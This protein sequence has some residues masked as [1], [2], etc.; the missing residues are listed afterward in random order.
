M[1][2]TIPLSSILQASLSKPAGYYEA[3]ISKGKIV[4]SNLELS[5]QSY[6]ELRSNFSNPQKPVEQKPVEQ[7]PVEQKPVEQKPVE[8]KP[9]EQKPVEQKP[10]EQKPVEQKPVDSS[11]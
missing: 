2:K 1:K 10:V 3:C 9:V 4:G 7:K 5:I 8:Q 6:N 11:K